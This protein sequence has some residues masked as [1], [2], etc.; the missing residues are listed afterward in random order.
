MEK[1]VIRKVMTV[2]SEYCRKKDSCYL[3]PLETSCHTAPQNWV[4]K[5]ESEDD[6]E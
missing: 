5:E 4:I 3:C 6:D 2:V 1:E